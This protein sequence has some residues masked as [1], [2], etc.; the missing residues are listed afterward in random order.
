[1][2]KTFYYSDDL[3][4]EL[5]P[6]VENLQPLPEN[7]SYGSNIFTRAVSFFLYRF[8][9][10]PLAW[11][12]MKIRFHH[13]FKNKKALK[14]IRGGYF[15][16]GNHTTLLGD[17]L[18]P[19]LLSVRKRNYIITGEQASSLHRLLWLMKTV[20]NI[21]LGR[22]PI[23]QRK[24]LRSVKKHIAAGSSVTVF[25]EAHVWPYYTDIRPF[26]SASIRYAVLTDA[27]IVTLTTCFKKRRFTKTPRIVS[28]VDGPFYPRKDISHTEAAELLRDEVYSAMKARCNE[29]STYSYHKY[30]KKD[31]A[32]AVAEQS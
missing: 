19:N 17:A 11:C 25:P 2:R 23:Q 15:I 6:T 13:S 20:G 12:Y 21:P 16:F 30:V 7:Y 1:M 9:A 29:H 32:A 28:F 5:A 26:S 3:N 31:E 18:M 4:D 24:M 22:T 10:F 14:G 8:V 27:P